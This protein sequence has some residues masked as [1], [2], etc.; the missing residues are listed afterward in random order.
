[1]AAN[2]LT[3]NCTLRTRCTLCKNNGMTE[4]LRARRR[5][6]TPIEIHRA[7]LRLVRERG[8]EKVTVEEISEEAGVSR[9]TFFN[10]F[11]SKE[12]AVVYGPMQLPADLTAAFIAKGPAHP[13]EVLADLVELLIQELAESDPR[14]GEMRDVHGIAMQYPSVHAV[15]LAQFEAFRRSVAQ[16]VAD[17]IGGEA[18][19]ET[20]TLLAAIGLTTIRIGLERWSTAE[21]DEPDDSPL[22]SIEQSAAVLRA[23]FAP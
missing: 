3:K 7:A 16:A 9:R 19:D 18:G 10:Y 23:L 17:R 5:R 15:Q 13:R 4:T 21:L 22:A 12:A 1:M 6:E 8:L 2:R 11:G 20:P 14:P